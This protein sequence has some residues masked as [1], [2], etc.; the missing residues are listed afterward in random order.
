MLL[1][2]QVK[3]LPVSLHR[4]PERIMTGRVMFVAVAAGG[5]LADGA[6]EEPW[7]PPPH[8]G[9]GPPPPPHLTTM[10]HGGCT[11]PLE[12]RAPCLDNHQPSW[13]RLQKQ[14]PPLPLEDN[15]HH[16][17]QQE[18]PNL[19]HLGSLGSL[20]SPHHK[21]PLAKSIKSN[22]ENTTMNI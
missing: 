3:M 7:R 4:L 12:A 8:H 2:I 17:L 9:A 16:H 18:N 21:Q 19:L 1:N 10:A 20:E 14:R 5:E 13:E 6:W 11:T 15:H 22:P